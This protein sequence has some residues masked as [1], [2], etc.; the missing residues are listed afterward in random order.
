MQNSGGIQKENKVQS[1]SQKFYIQL[2]GKKGGATRKH[3]V[4]SNT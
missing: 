1:L 2:G 4:L 3:E